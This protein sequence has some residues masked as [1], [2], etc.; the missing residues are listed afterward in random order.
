MAVERGFGRRHR[1][2]WP[3]AA[4]VPRR[5]EVAAV[6][7]DRVRDGRAAEGP[8]GRHEPG[9][10]EHR[11]RR[12]DVALGERRRW[13]ARASAFDVDV[14]QQGRE[15]WAARR[16]GGAAA[17]R[18]V[19]LRGAAAGSVADGAEPRRAPPDPSRARSSRRTAS[20]RLDVTPLQN[21]TDGPS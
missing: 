12:R 7:V 9:E 11:A 20:Q 15:L 5:V 2:F 16:R 18:D 14:G 19:D 21:L 4:R 13:A 3:V 8:S 10:R 17:S 6:L 1:V